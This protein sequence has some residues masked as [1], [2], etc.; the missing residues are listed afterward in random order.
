M[1]DDRQRQAHNYRRHGYGF[2]YRSF[3]LIP[4][5]LRTDALRRHRVE[6][7]RYLP[8]RSFH[9][10]MGGSLAGLSSEHIAMI[11]LLRQTLQSII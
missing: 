11:P 5:S 8:F 4:L 9:E 1:Y 10:G 7:G 2:L 3:A 6:R